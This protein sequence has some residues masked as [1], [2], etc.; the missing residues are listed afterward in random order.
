MLPV[1]AVIVLYHPEERVVS[2]VEALMDECCVVVVVNGAS[3]GIVS[4]IE[5]MNGVILLK[6]N[7]NIGLG[8]ALNLGLDHAFSVVNSE[9]AFVFDQDSL[10][11]RDFA[12]KM[13]L[14]LREANRIDFKPACIGP[15]LVDR[16]SPRAKVFALNYNNEGFASVDSLATSGTLISREAF[17][18][19]GPMRS[20]FFIDAID[21][22]WCFRAKSLGYDVL[23][24]NKVTMLH[25]MGVSAINLYGHFKPVHSSPVRHYY[26]TRNHI[27]LLRQSYIPLRWRVLE[28]FKIIRRSLFYVM[29]SE[30]RV[31]TLYMIFR[32]IIDGVR[33]K[34]GEL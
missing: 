20:D 19:C 7:S 10:V 34:L 9:A 31:K 28:F 17:L 33:G 1:S 25:D 29:V 18:A 27:Y 14:A 15:V 22:E 11:A 3:D 6:N 4:K 30:S 12:R 32:G 2:L 5:R 21:H 23:S 26:I 13:F 16:K 24:C 8:A